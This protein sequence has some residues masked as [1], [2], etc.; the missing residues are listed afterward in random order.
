[1]YL[2]IRNTLP[3]LV[4]ALWLWLSWHLWLGRPDLADIPDALWDLRP[5]E[6]GI[7]TWF[8]AMIAAMLLADRLWCKFTR[9]RI[10]VDPMRVHWSRLRNTEGNLFCARCQSIFLL[11]PEDLSLGGIVH[12]GD[13]GHAIA[14]YG[15]MKP[16]LEQHGR[17]RLKQLASR[18][19]R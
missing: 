13:C 2:T 9:W 1:M 3:W 19:R 8:A 4:A 14:T 17:Y 12:C 5:S 11:P 16:L 6:F 18:L 10:G 15:E 7:F